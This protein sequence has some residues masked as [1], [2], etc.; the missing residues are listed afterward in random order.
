MLNTNNFFGIKQY[1]FLQELKDNWKDILQE[2]KNIH[3]LAV[4]WPEKLIYTQGWSV[5]GLRFQDIDYLDNQAL[6]PI[7]TKIIKNIPNVQNAG[8]SILKS[9]TIIHPH[10]GYTNKVLRCHLGLICPDNAWIKVGNDIKHWKTG[11]IFVFDD[12]NM[13][14]AQNNS[15]Q[16][17]VI[18]IIDFYR[19]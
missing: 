7:S 17:R 10:V 4:E 9:S 2:Y 12:T 3:H 6:C 19:K 14:E 13:H 16:D 1:P 15:D 18:M 5:I 8:F 11:E